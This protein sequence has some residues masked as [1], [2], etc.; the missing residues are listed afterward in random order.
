MRRRAQILVVPLSPP[1]APA[2]PDGERQ[3]EAPTLDALRETLRC[4][5]ERE[6]RRVRAVSF[7]K[8]GMLAYVEEQA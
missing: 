6:G 5:L 3:V 2:R 4:E 8:D 7:T 1:N